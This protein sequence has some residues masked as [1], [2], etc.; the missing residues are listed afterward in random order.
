MMINKNVSCLVE[1]VPLGSAKMKWLVD[2][3]R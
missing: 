3:K 1:H 2:E